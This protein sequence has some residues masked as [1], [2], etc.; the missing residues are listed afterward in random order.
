M[1]TEDTLTLSLAYGLAM[2]YF[3]MSLFKVRAVKSKFGLMVTVVTQ[4]CFAI[5]S[6]FTVC[7]VFNIDLSRIPRAAYPVALLAMSL[8]NIFRLIN[9]VIRTPGMMCMSRS[10]S[11]QVM[12]GPRPV[13]NQPERERNL[14][15]FEHVDSSASVDDSKTGLWFLLAYVDLRFVL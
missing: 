12:D 7:A 15:A 8:E 3:V 14:V 5:M 6:S 13:A 11:V 10:A 1:S 9:A 2:G 4:I